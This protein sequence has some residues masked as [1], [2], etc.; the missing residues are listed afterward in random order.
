MSTPSPGAA[1]S[2]EPRPRNGS[3]S[4][5]V[6]MMTN[7]LD[8]GYAEAAARRSGAATQPSAGIR[9]AAV[10]ARRRLTAVVLVA[11]L[12][13]LTGTAAAQVRSRQAAAVGVRGQLIADVKHQTASSDQLARQADALRREVAA[14]QAAALNADAAGRVAARQLAALELVTGVE[15]VSGPG[16]LVRLD[17]APG[18]RNQSPTPGT[19]AGAGR[20][21]DRDLQDAA[22]G[23]WAAGAEAVA[24][25][26]LRLTALTAIRS[27]GDAILVDLRPVSPPYTIQAIGN[28]DRIGAAFVD[29][30]AGRR[31]STYTSLYGL[32]F[33]VR[34]VKKQT[35]PGTGFADLLFARPV[36]HAS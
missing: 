10:G 7:T 28:P 5:L 33:T 36:G 1:G 23:L 18:S 21:L 2:P 3:M 9:P 24:I 35:L 8:S 30:P 12:G 25:N 6:D 29:G 32:Q 22:N 34:T 31:L 14:A 27:A 19:Q 26:N 4:L 11:T 17:D 20:V 13:V 15:P 16:L